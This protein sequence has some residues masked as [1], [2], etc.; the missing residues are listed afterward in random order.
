VTRFRVLLLLRLSTER[1]IDRQPTIG[2]CSLVIRQVDIVRAQARLLMHVM[3]RQPDHHQT[4][5][6]PPPPVAFPFGP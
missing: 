6:R 4:G 5:L 2:A 1:V 3:A